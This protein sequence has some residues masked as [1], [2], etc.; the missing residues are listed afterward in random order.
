MELNEIIGLRNTGGREIESE[1][2]KSVEIPC[3]NKSGLEKILEE[4]AGGYWDPMRW[5]K[6]YFNK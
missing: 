2:K 3:K 5:K 4:G 6:T 1:L